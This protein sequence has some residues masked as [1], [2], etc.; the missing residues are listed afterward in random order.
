MPKLTFKYI[1]ADDYNPIFVNGAWGGV[2]P[3]GEITISFY[4][5]RA[6]LPI[7]ET[8]EINDKGILGK[9]LEK[10][11]KDQIVVR[12]IENGLVLTLE[13]AKAI[14]DFLGQRI[15]E[16]EDIRK[17]ALAIDLKKN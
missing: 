15:K 9:V 5:E 11:P 16:A 14:H 6:G 8:H 17:Q 12:Y 7:T 10:I 13:G 2:T 3:S 4:L 1:F